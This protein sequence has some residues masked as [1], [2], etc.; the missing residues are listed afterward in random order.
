MQTNSKNNSPYSFISTNKYLLPQSTP[1][2]T[3]ATTGPTTE[4][5]TG[6]DDKS[7]HSRYNQNMMPSTSREAGGHP[8]SVKTRTQVQALENQKKSRRNATTAIETNPPEQTKPAKV[9]P[10]F[11]NTTRTIRLLDW[12]YLHRRRSA[13]SGNPSLQEAGQ[14]YLDIFAHEKYVT[15]ERIVARLKVMKH[16]FE[17][18]TR[19][20]AKQAASQ[21]TEKGM[22]YMGSIRI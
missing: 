8:S 10:I 12:I 2:L 9:N 17:T 16:E 6:S 11:W 18:T 21:E 3:K 7:Y 15:P 4:V 19:W 13:L 22:L 5:T 20:L 1:V 14:I